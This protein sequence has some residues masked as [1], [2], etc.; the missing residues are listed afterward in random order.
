LNYGTFCKD[1]RTIDAILHNLFVIGEAA[2]NLS[3][4]FLAKYSS[5]PWKKIKGLRD[6]IAH[7]YFGIDYPLI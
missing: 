1:Q 3:P 6:I 2:K 4:K 7:Q 5:I